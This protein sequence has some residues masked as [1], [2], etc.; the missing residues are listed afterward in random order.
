MKKKILVPVDLSDATVQVCN[1]A[2]D[3]A[4]ALDAR[5]L[6]LHAVEPDPLANSYYALSTFEIATLTGNTRKRTALRMKA[7]GHWFQKSVPDTKIVLH[8]GRALPTILRVA[9]MARPDYIIIGSHG[10]SAAYEM[11]AGS[12]AHGVLR[13][14]ACP[15]VM[16]PIAP[17]RRGRIAQRRGVAEMAGVA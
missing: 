12:V 6:I 15:V 4:R 2:R 10:H 5:L 11:L 17:R 16:V 3:L 1:A 13:K 8:S 9:R 14:A 7:L